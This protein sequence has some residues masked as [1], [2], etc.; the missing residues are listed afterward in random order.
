MDMES[1][2]RLGGLVAPASTQHATA[3]GEEKASGDAASDR[4]GSDADT[5][6]DSEE[7]AAACRLTTYIGRAGRKGRVQGQGGYYSP[8]PPGPGR[9]QR[10]P[11]GPKPPGEI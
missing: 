9:V 3:L 4:D 11:K 8:R 10:R 1:I 7:D 2:L 6:E 5:G